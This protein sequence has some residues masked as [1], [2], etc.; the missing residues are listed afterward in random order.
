MLLHH[1]LHWP[2]QADSGIQP[3]AMDYATWI[4]NKLAS[5]SSSYFPEE[6]FLLTKSFHVDIN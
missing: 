1:A 2:Q 4:W 5:M 3:F 6:I